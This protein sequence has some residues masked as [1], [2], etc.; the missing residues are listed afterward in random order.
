MEIIYMYIASLFNTKYAH[1]FMIFVIYNFFLL[2]DTYES[3]LEAEKQI[4]ATS[5]SEE[6]ESRM[7][8]RKV[9]NNKY[10]NYVNFPNPP[11]LLL[12][13]ESHKS[14]IAD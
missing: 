14:G 13:K 6:A 10:D 1:Y 11:R 7:G 12:S 2:L 5:E 3:A 4:V 8:K 9:K